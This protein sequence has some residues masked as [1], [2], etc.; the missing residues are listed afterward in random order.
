MDD[1]IK[2]MRIDETR[3]LNHL[4]VVDFSFLPD[5]KEK[6]LPNPNVSF[7]AAPQYKIDL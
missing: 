6:N 3:A 4:D 2:A 7:I 5:T 1:I